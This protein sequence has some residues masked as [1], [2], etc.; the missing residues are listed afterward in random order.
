VAQSYGELVQ[1][2]VPFFLPPTADGGSVYATF[3]DT[4]HNLLQLMQLG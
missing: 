3:R 1:R 4:E 2:G